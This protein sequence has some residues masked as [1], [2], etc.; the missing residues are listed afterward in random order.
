MTNNIENLKIETKS[1][2]YLCPEKIREY[3]KD[4]DYF[5]A[6]T[7]DEHEES[8]KNIYEYICIGSKRRVATVAEFYSMAEIIC[9]F[10]FDRPS[11]IDEITIDCVV[12]CIINNCIVFEN[13]IRIVE[14]EL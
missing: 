8:S 6:R 3:I 11:H 2:P 9:K 12:E 7:S 4:Q 1:T 5:N 13:D 14:K 10:S